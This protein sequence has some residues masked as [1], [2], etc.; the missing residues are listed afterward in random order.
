M[1]VIVPRERRVC[2]EK[3]HR[4]TSGDRE[5]ASL[6]RLDVGLHHARSA[7]LARIAQQ[8]RGP[9]ELPIEAHLESLDR[10]VEAELVPVAE[11]I[12]D[13]LRRV[14]E[15]TCAKQSIARDQLSVHA[16]RGAARKSK[17]LAQM[18]ADLGV[19]ASHSR[20]RVSNDNPFSEAQFTTLKYQPS[21]PHRFGGYEHAL[22]Y[23]RAFFPWYNNDH[24]HSGIAMLTPADVYYG[25]AAD[26]VTERQRFLDAAYAARPERFVKGPPTVP[27]LPDAVWINPPED[28]TRSELKTTKFATPVS[29]SR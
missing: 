15:E 1:L 3:R 20:P 26:V 18:L 8:V 29:P 14:V 23:C 22:S 19:D 21:Y 17:T 25:R 2:S 7:A 13:G 6:Q 4:A 10:H 16:D 9:R 5:R 27:A 12:D 28:K 11:A 24:R